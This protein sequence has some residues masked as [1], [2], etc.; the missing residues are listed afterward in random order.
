MLGAVV[1]ES[2]SL[3]KKISLI[4]EQLP[5]YILIFIGVKNIALIHCS[6]D[7]FHQILEPF[8]N[9]ALLL[10]LKLQRPFTL[11]EVISEVLFYFEL[12]KLLCFEDSFIH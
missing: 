9:E 8:I 3:E 2:I 10:R 7:C 11:R 4:A 5:C 1:N 6:Q 12:D